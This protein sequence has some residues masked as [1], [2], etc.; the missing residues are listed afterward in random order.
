MGRRR[1]VVAR[2]RRS[3]RPEVLRLWCAV[4]AFTTLAS[5][6]GQALLGDASGELVAT[7]LGVAAGAVLVMLVDALVPEALR[8]GGKAAGLV[9]V[10][11][12]AVTVLL[13][14]AP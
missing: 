10:L 9:T 11:G 4:A 3:D 6:L 8:S 13:S 14:S 1:I 5:V 7:I 2:A 12:F